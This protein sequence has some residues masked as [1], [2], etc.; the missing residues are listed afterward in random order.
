M[1]KGALKYII[2]GSITALGISMVIISLS[3]DKLGIY[4]SLRER[5]SLSGS[6][7]ISVS[8]L[9]ME[10]LNNIFIENDIKK[11]D[12][13]ISYGTV[14]IS[15]GSVDT[16]GI[17]INTKN[18]VQNKFKYEIKGNTLYVKYTDGLKLFGGLT[19]R[20]GTEINVTFPKNAKYDDIYISNGAGVINFYD[21]EAEDITI[22]NGAGEMK[23]KNISVNGKIKINTGAGIVK[24]ESTACKKLEIDSGVGAVDAD[25][26]VCKGLDADIGVGGLTYEGEINGDAEIDNAVGEVKMTLYGNASDYGFDVDSAGVGK[27]KVDGST[28]FNKKGKHKFE[29]DTGIGEVKINFKDKGEW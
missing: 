11:V 14:N 9:E 17:A 22:D 21:L 6:D 5:E 8:V 13:N 19:G 1:K 3:I 16:D 23:M 29:I 12:I 15:R 7:S 10:D 25:N 4:N 2:G 26:V 24:L 18:I 20:A 28:V 27:V